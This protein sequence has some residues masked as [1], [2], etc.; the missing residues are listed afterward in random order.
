MVL[1]ILGLF[2]GCSLGVFIISLLVKSKEA[3]FRVCQS[4]E[5]SE[6]VSSRRE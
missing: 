3:A 1:F 2:V 6:M 5:S 4:Q